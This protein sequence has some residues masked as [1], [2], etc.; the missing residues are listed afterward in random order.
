MF[1]QIQIDVDEKTQMLIIQD[2]PHL[3]TWIVY[4]D[5]IYKTLISLE[6]EAFVFLK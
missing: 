2:N 4:P 5:N 3:S 6:I 1:E